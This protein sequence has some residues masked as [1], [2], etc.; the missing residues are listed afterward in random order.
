[1]N[2]RGRSVVLRHLLNG[3]PVQTLPDTRG[4]GIGIVDQ[5]G[6][7]FGVWRET[8]FPAPREAVTWL[9]VHYMVNNIACSRSPL[10]DQ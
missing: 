8:Q 3:M 4:L 9:V 2:F 7:R 10:S 1:M 5:H 6:I